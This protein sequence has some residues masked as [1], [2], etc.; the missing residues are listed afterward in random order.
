MS[1][2]IHELEIEVRKHKGIARDLRDKNKKIKRLVRE[3]L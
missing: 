2:R 3:L 1:Q